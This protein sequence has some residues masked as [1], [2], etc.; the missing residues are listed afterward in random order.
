[1]IYNY[2]YS[3]Q[4]ERLGSNGK[5][6]KITAAEL[7]KDEG[8][9]F[10]Q[11]TSKPTNPRADSAEWKKVLR[12]ARVREARSHDA[13]HTAATMLLVLRVPIL[14]VPIRA[15]LDVMGWSQASM[16]TRYQHMPRGAG[17]H[18]AADG[19]SSLG[20]SER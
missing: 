12:D 16:T 9:V 6:W 19:W 15:V 5:T 8:W 13:R 7:W 2:L 18:R 1:M 17:R 4:E 11:A 20:R 10:A 3:K 14:R